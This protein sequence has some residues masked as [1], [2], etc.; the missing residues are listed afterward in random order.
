[1]YPRTLRKNEIHIGARIFCIADTLDAM[2]SDRPYRK[3]TSFTNAI[4]E[5]SRC[6]GTQ[7]DPEV[8]RAFLDIGETGLIKI[9]DDMVARKAELHEKNQALLTEP[10][11]PAVGNSG[12]GNGTNGGSAPQ[13]PPRS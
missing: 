12:S 6:A 4:Q 8:V 13:T 11:T 10:K 7:F 3:G 2:T 5:I 9:R 1:G